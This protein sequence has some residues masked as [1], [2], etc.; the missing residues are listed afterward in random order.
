MHSGAASAYWQGAR[1]SGLD[2]HVMRK[3]KD[4]LASKSSR[5]AR[6]TSEQTQRTDSAY[7][8]H[9]SV[10]SAN[11][12]KVKGCTGEQAPQIFKKHE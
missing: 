1:V 6:S 12:R 3:R 4:A 11:L 8:Q 2:E 9:E 5:F 7:F 10:D